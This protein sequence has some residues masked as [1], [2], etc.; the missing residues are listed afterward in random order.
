MRG[1]FHS[2][3]APNFFFSPPVLLFFSLTYSLKNRTCLSEVIKR[4]SLTTK[5]TSGTPASF[6]VLSGVGG[7]AWDSDKEDNQGK[8]FGYEKI[9]SF[10]KIQKSMHQTGFIFVEMKILKE[11]QKIYLL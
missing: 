8:L 7:A 10:V 9:K 11:K 5:D 1:I 3:I 2:K 6:W 4:C